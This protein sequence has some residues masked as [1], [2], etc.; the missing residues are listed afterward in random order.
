MPSPFG[1][2][3]NLR[4]P[5]HTLARISWSSPIHPARRASPGAALRFA[6][7]SELGAYRLARGNSM[8]MA[9]MQVPL[10]LS[11]FV[12]MSY[13]DSPPLSLFSTSRLVVFIVAIHSFWCCLALWPSILFFNIR[14]RSF[15]NSRA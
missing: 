10:G 7:S 13:R 15:N 2:K 6:R 4:I 5:H 12:A 8:G 9:C 11:S 1:R 14:L 3:S